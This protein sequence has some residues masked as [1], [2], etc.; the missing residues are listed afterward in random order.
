MKR[1]ATKIRRSPPSLQQRLDAW[2]E[3]E[4]R[5]FAEIERIGSVVR[6][7]NAR[8]DAMEWREW[9]RYQQLQRHHRAAKKRFAKLRAQM[10]G[11]RPPYLRDEF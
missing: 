4:R 6:A 1:A 3:H 5:L 11:W 10:P 9:V 2:H 7:L 8:G